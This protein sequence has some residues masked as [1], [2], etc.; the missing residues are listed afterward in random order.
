MEKE[1]SEETKIVTAS[2]SVSVWRKPSDQFTV[3][4]GSGVKYFYS[5]NVNFIINIYFDHF[6][7]LPFFPPVLKAEKFEAKIKKNSV[8][9]IF[10][11]N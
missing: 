5:H 2:L 9:N 6:F 10:Q 1:A 7:P 11:E 4:K 8:Y 3:Q